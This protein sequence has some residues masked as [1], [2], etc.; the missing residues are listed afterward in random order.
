MPKKQ[1]SVT[2]ITFLWIAAVERHSQNAKAILAEMERESD[3]ERLYEL[4]PPEWENGLSLIYKNSF[5]NI[6]V[7]T[8]RSM[9]MH[10]LKWKWCEIWAI[11]TH[12]LSTNDYEHLKGRDL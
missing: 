1:R 4:N 2:D 5:S 9:D 12:N 7:N 6:Y 11:K 3:T 10:P 8:F